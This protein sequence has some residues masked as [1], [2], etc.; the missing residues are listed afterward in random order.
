MLGDK[1]EGIMKGITGN[2]KKPESNSQQTNPLQVS[3][4]PRPLK[5]SPEAQILEKKLIQYQE[6]V[7]KYLLT[8]TNYS[9]L[10]QFGEYSQHN[11]SEFQKKNFIDYAFISYAL[12]IIYMPMRNEEKEYYREKAKYIESILKNINT[13][14]KIV[15]SEGA[16]RSDFET[17]SEIAQKLYDN[18]IRLSPHFQ[19]FS[20]K[21]DFLAQKLTK[22]APEIGDYLQGLAMALKMPDSLPLLFSELDISGKSFDI[23]QRKKQI[24]LE[25]KTQEIHEY[26]TLVENMFK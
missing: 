26:I 19:G 7:Q 1:L 14:G 6:D 24:E 20:M 15:A 11:A 25:T 4:T 10:F 8:G 21:L 2:G 9:V 22:I 16:N 3:Q 23:T 18:D 17:I 12:N 5:L 13:I